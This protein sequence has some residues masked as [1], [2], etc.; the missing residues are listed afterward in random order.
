MK[1]ISI[2][3][4]TALS[5]A[6]L[7][8]SCGKVP[9]A[10]VDAANAAIDSAKIAGADIYLIEDYAALQDSMNSINA[11]IEAQKSKLFKNFDA[12]KEQLAYVT[13]L[14]TEVK[15]KTEAR[16]EEV[17]QEVLNVQTEVSSILAQNN[18][19]LTKAPRGK[20]GTAAL[21]AIKSDLSLI[22]SSNSEVSNM[23]L[24]GQLLPALDKAN[25]AKE[26][27]LAINSELN[28]VIARYNKNKRR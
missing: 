8:S 1:K 4:L 12:V 28:E 20:E 19:L 22:E 7:F 23:V 26:K 10:E 3:F 2:L 5:I 15:S 16:K 17:K 25:A 9:Q 18:D 27:A 24:D 6:V 13:T 11:S 21:E 14:A